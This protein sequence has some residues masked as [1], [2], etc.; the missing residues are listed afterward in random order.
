MILISTLSTIRGVMR[1]IPYLNIRSRPFSRTRESSL[2]F[3]CIISCPMFYSVCTATAPARACP[4]SP[5]LLILSHWE[6]FFS[7][8]SFMDDRVNVVLPGLYLSQCDITSIKPMKHE[9]Y[10]FRFV[11]KDICKLSKTLS[12][13]DVLN[14]PNVC[15]ESSL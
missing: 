9:K 3:T 14:I 10:Q 6:S 15:L 1:R 13:P 5:Y 7:Y 8:H 2:P 4:H 11:D 12:C